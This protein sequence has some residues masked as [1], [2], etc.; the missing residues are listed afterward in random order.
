[1]KRRVTV[2]TVALVLAIALTLAVIAIMSALV[3]NSINHQAPSQ[4]LGENTTQ[5]IIA[6][7][8]GLIG[9]LGGYIGARVHR[10]DDEER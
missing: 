10:R 2:D 7:V 5:V 3:I 6:I 1:V 8:G 9:V 4:T